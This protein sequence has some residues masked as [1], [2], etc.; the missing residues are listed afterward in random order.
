[1]GLLPVSKDLADHRVMSCTAWVQWP[2]LGQPRGCVTFTS[3]AS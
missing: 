2:F 1:M 3:L